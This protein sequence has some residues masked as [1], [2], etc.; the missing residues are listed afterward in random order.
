MTLEDALL[1]DNPI[2]QETV[3]GV[4]V[5]LVSK[6]EGDPMDLNRVLVD[7]PTLKVASAWARVA[8]FTA[9]ANRGAFFFPAKNDEV[10]VAFE[11]GDVS[12]P[13]VIGALW[14]GVDHAPVPTAKIANVRRLMTSSGAYLEFDDSEKGASITITDK[15]RNTITIDTKKDTI[16][17]SAK[18]DL[19]L[20]APN[21]KLT[22]KGGS[23][24]ITASTGNLTMSATGNASVKAKGEV[25]VKGSLVRLN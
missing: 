6:T 21:G 14:N 10:L 4:V 9:G 17:I 24:D 25:A 12:R 8:S 3:F 18:R 20:S 15:N 5:G 1:P 2:T 23:V 22:L 16:T 7:F 13:Y 11:L 19:I